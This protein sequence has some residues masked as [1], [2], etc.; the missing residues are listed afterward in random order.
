ML[1]IIYSFYEKIGYTYTD[2]IVGFIAIVIFWFVTPL[3]NDFLGNYKEIY[4]KSKQHIKTVCVILFFILH[5]IN[6]H[7]VIEGIS[8]ACILKCFS[9]FSRKLKKEEINIKDH[10]QSQ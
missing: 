8:M 7:S 10:N 4:T 6:N 3:T 2:K 9:L 1:F 5:F